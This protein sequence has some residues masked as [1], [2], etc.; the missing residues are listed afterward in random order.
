ME[1]IKV[2]VS[3]CTSER[4]EKSALPSFSRAAIAKTI[5]VSSEIMT[6]EV[7][8]FACKFVDLLDGQALDGSGVTIEEVELALAVTASGGVQLLG[9]MTAGVQASITIKLKRSH[10]GA[11]PN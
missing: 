4:S 3:D 8:A 10:G 5:E 1:S 6:A 7:K 9:S 2:L 11:E